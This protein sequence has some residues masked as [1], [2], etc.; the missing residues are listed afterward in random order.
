MPLWARKPIRD[1]EL[2]ASDDIGPRMSRSLGLGNLTM[3][4]V[5]SA[6]GA[7]IFVLTGTAAANFA[8]PAVVWSFLI[9]SVGCLC[10][11]LCYAELAS[12]IP[13]AGSAYTYAYASMGELIAWIIGWSLVLE[14]LFSVS[15]IAVGWSG[16]FTAFLVDYGVPVDST[17]TQPPIAHDADGSWRS[18]GA[19]ANLPAIGIVLALTAILARGV[20]ESAFFNNLMAGV[21]LAVI[22]LVIGFGAFH[23]DP[24]NWQPFVPENS[25][26]P[27]H[28]GWSGVVRAAGLVFFAYIG[29]DAVS[30]SAQEARNPRRDVPL[31]ILLSL[32]ICTVLYVAMSLIMTGLAPYSLLDV[33][34]PIFVAVDH[35]GSGLAWL[36]PIV[37]VGAIVGLASAM[38]ATLY[39]QIRIF[40][41]MSK[42][43]MLPEAFGLL[44]PRH[45]TPS[46]GTWY[47]GLAAALIAGFVPI[48]VLGELASIGTLLAFV[49]VCVGVLVLRRREPLAPRRFRLRFPRTAAYSGIAI[50]LYMMIN[51]PPGT[52]IRLAVWLTLGLAIYF[53]YGHRRSKLRSPSAAAI[54]REPIAIAQQD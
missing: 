31:G 49:I 35:A 17:W 3:I 54:A 4:G 29:F 45:R 12:M 2:D 28:F 7:G 16:Y 33:P 40:Y 19:T 10:A 26:E 5:G 21:K 51:L 13:V 30:T 36:K 39:G 14:Y 20:R 34:Q 46:L 27:G 37:G 50:C 25:G 44:H 6:I 41:S 24:A 43:G 11:A 47:S 8:G 48:G 32:A 42:D 23:V 1:L 38:L 52:W 9:A 53:A 15:T 22:V 18:S